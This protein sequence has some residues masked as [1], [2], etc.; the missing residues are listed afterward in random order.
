MIGYISVLPGA[1]SAYR[2]VALSGD[3][4]WKDYFKS[5]CHPELMDA[6]HSNIY[7]AEDRVLCMSLVS[8]P[9]KNYIL[10]YVR[11]SIAETD[12]PE[13]LAVLMSQRR[14]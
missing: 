1:F 3:P 14:R 11:K 8:V 12:V 5:L 4:L 7:L 6:F 10:R 13:S 2:W 9:G